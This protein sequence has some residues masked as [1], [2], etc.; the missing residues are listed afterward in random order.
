L[1]RRYVKEGRRK[2]AGWRFD[3][4]TRAR[5]GVANGSARCGGAGQWCK[6]ATRLN[7]RKET[8][9]GDGPNGPVQPNGPAWQLG[10]RRVSGQN[11]GFE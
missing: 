11:Q 1:T 3:S 10:W 6:A 5:G 4:S 2:E 7:Q 9:Q 8:T